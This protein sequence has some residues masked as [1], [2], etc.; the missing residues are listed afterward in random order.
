MCPFCVEVLRRR[1]D[2][3]VTALGLILTNKLRF[4][5]G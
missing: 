5:Q 1:R 3:D 4:Q 2:A